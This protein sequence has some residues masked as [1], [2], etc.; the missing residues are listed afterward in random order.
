[1]YG[2]AVGSNSVKKKPSRTALDATCC[3]IMTAAAVAATH[4][5][6]EKGRDFRATPA[7]SSGGNYPSRIDRACYLRRTDMFIV[8]CV[9]MVMLRP[10]AVIAISVAALMSPVVFGT[11][12]FKS[13]SM[14]EVP[15][16]L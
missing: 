1:M 3:A 8:I 2:S 4:T 11:N 16:A 15:V 5:T 14:S 13:R 6:D 7:L 9:F 12:V 10:P